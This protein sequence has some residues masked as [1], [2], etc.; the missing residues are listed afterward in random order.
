MRCSVVWLASALG[1]ALGTP[2]Y[3]A[4]PAEILQDHARTVVATA[5]AGALQSGDVSRSEGSSLVSFT[6][7]FTTADAAR[8]SVPGAEQDQA[9]FEE[10]RKRGDLWKSQFCTDGLRTEMK[11]QKIDMVRGSVTDAE[12]KNE[13]VALCVRK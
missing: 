12:G 11:R 6:V 8:L 1:F 4:S 3:A 9:K 5:P 10:S 13:L 7:R 2:V